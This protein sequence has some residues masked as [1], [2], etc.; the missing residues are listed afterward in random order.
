VHLEA[1]HTAILLEWVLAGNLGL[2]RTPHEHSWSFCTR[3][4]VNIAN[5]DGDSALLLQTILLQQIYYYPQVI[6]YN[7]SANSQP[8]GPMLPTGSY[9][10]SLLENCDVVALV[11]ELPG[12]VI[13]D[14]CMATAL[15]ANDQ[16]LVSPD[17][18]RH[19]PGS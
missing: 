1:T 15:G 8:I 3:Q 4:W 18:H 7:E 13:A 16:A 12:Q 10:L 2:H 6:Q 5:Q 19:T 17:A 9:L 14:E 11:H